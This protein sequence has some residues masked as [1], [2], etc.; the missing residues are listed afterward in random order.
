MAW[1]G[2]KYCVSVDDLTRDDRTAVDKS[3]RLA[4]ILSRVNYHKLCQRG[5]IIVLRRGGGRG[6]PAL[7]DFESLP[8]DVKVRYREKYPDDKQD[9]EFLRNLCLEAYQ[10]DSSALSYYV[11]ELHLRHKSL[12]GERILELAQEY[13]TNVSV[14][15]AVI[16]IKQDASLYRKVRQGRAPSWS[17]MLGV[18]GYFR[19]E[20]GHT[21]GG[22]ATRFAQWVKRYEA[23]GLDALISKKFGN[24]SR[25]KVSVLVEKILLGID[26]GDDFRPY[27]TVVA[28]R[29]NAFLSGDLVLF[30]AD[31]NPID[32]EQLRDAEGRLPFL[33]EK[34]VRNY[35]KKENNR[36]MRSKQHDS[37]HT[38][39]GLY[40]PY[41]LRKS[42]EYSLSKV[43]LD[44][45][46]LMMK[47][48]WSDERVDRETGEIK[49]H[50]EVTALKVYLSYDV[51][52]QCII[53]YA[54]SGKKGI[55]QIEDCVRSM[56]RTLV[57]HGL[58][59]PAEAE[60]ENHLVTK[61][62]DTL[63]GD[64]HLF[65]EVTWCAPGNSQQKRAEHMN[66]IFKY[67]I[68][69]AH[70]AGVGRHYST[71]EAHRSGKYHERV[72]DANNNRVKARYYRYEDAC[73]FY[74]MLFDKYNNDLHSDQKRYPGM[75]RWQVLIQRANP[76]LPAID[77]QSLARW[78]GERTKTSIKRTMC[79]VAGRTWRISSEQVLERL[80]PSSTRVEAQWWEQEL[81]K[82]D[83]IY[84]Y[85]NGIY[86]DTCQEQERYNEARCERTE[87]DESIRRQQEVY[88][89]R[90]RRYIEENEIK[91]IT[92]MPI[93]D[94]E[95][96]INQIPRAVGSA[97][98]PRSPEEEDIDLD[99]WLDPTFIRQRPRAMR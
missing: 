26:V 1:F 89:A 71:H 35:L 38:F 27:N 81:G 67:T 40:E 28:E 49:L 80:A 62:R 55:A 13:A 63:M 60:V 11:K 98:V 53:G 4:P 57:A 85:Q 48:L 20:F 70:I 37:Q 33:S 22:T 58:P 76:S 34:T 43:S 18:I 95:E 74:S 86:I 12:G 92:L 66:R 87:E 47:V 61:L 56:F 6:C 24:S 94:Y 84:L 90:H 32:R 78:A 41:N 5:K 16:R 25:R 68:E 2:K 51:A 99:E 50:H 10:F 82:I 39:K 54:F 9:N 7:I 23:E 46:D 8:D 96:I 45:R 3:D 59:R 14:I 17:E 36:M 21:L 65:G 88:R 15:K 93:E 97:A 83:Q 79:Q 64:G 72:S 73:E 42:P 69:K 77:M 19:E 30:D 44:D 91:P 31:G 29:F 52:S 75:T